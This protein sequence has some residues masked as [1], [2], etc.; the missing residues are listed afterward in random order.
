MNLEERMYRIKRGNDVLPTVTRIEV[1]FCDCVCGPLEM[2]EEAESLAIELLVGLAGC[3]TCSRAFILCG[4][5]ALCVC[6]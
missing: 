3:S 1:C 4:L 2:E 5:L 6:V